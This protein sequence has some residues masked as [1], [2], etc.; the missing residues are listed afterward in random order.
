[1]PRLGLPRGAAFKAMAAYVPLW[2]L[3]RA[4]TPAWANVNVAFSV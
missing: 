3:T 4:M 1:M 2:A